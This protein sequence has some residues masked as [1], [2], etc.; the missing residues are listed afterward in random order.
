VAGDQERDAV[1]ESRET[2]RDALAAL[3]VTALV[4]TNIVKAVIGHKPTKEDVKNRSPLV[5]VVSVGRARP[6]FTTQENRATFR[7]DVQLWV[8]IAD[9]VAWTPAIAEDRLD[10]MEATVAE[11]VAVN[12]ETDDWNCLIAEDDSV[13]GDV[14]YDG[15]P[16]VVEHLPVTVEVF[17]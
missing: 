11:V 5:A 7:F 4:D 13:I 14:G 2:S 1:T 17:K 10:L 8:L 3:L 15:V 12:Q 6:R 16:Y 9:G